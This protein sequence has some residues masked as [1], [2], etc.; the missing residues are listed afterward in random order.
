MT[1][2]YEKPVHVDLPFGEALE[3]FGQTKPHEVRQAMTDTREGRVRESD[4]VLP[5][6]RLMSERPNGFITTSDLIAELEA[7]FNPSGRDAEIIPGRTDTYFS[8][9]VRNLIS[10]R[11]TENSFIKN[12]FA[13]HDEADK[14]LRITDAGRKLLKTLGG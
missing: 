2:Q 13:D 7:V 5:S 8:Q 1:R 12:G 3:R 11:N 4:L 9:K 6:L 10:H 14:G